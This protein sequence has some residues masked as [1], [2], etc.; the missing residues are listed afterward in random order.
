M[1]ALAT[2]VIPTGMVPSQA[3]SD[4]Q[5][6]ALWLHGKSQQTQ[7]SYR[8]TVLDFLT[9][10]AV[11]LP[12]VCLQD[13]Q[14]YADALSDRGLA[15]GSQAAALTA[16]KSVLSFASTIGYTSFNVGAAV[17]LPKVRQTLAAR[18]VT[19]ETA[20]AVM[21]GE[22]NPRNHALLRLLYFGGLRVSEISTLRWRD[23]NPRDDDSG[24]VTVYG[25]GGKTR[26]ILLPAHV[27]RDVMALRGD[28]SDDEPVFCG[29]GG[30]LTASQV[31]RIVKA[32]G[33]RAGVPGLSPHW[34][35]HAHASHALDAGAAIHVV[36]DTLG[37]ASVATTSRYLHARPD[38]SSSMYL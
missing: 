25:K 34:L 37:H 14:D 2:V 5:L 21:A 17:P 31:A 7:R 29:R 28:A 22:T 15:D 13:V 23:L 38:A 4:A 8:R 24:Q 36:R 16:V 33:V 18:I 1:S 26:A 35:R 11:P 30:A 10:V 19:R 12:Q 3:T 6:L 32:A 9:L 27:W 20:A